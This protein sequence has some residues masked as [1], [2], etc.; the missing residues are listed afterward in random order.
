MTDDNRIDWLGLLRTPELP[1]HTDAMFTSAEDW[2]NNACLNYM[3]DG[4]TFY[5][6]GYKEAAD[7]LVERS[8]R[9]RG[10]LDTLVYPILFLYRQYLELEIK[11]LIRLGRQLEDID[12]S[13]P[14]HHRLNDLWDTCSKILRR[15]APGDSL[16]EQNQIGRLIREFCKV[17]PLSMAFRYPEDRDGK[18][19]LPSLSHINVLNTKVVIGKI[20]VILEGADAMIGEYLSY[21]SE[22]YSEYGP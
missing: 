6:S 7:L 10:S 12:E 13:F 2:W 14:K 4:W 5:A 3:Q 21:K 22:M 17:D 18:P 15:I 1:V 16:E 11:N 20:S 9:N 19:S 8:E